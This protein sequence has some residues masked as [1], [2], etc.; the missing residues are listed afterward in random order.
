MINKNY[1]FSD[2]HYLLKNYNFRQVF[3]IKMP[4]FERR[5]NI[6]IKIIYI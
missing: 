2:I 4:F 3:K 1:F 5:L 6:F